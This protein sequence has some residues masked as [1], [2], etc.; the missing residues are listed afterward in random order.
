MTVRISPEMCVAGREL[1]EPRLSP[2]GTRLAYSVSWGGRSAIAVVDLGTTGP[3][4]ERLATSEPQPRTG[5]GLGGG[6]GRW[7]VCR[8]PDGE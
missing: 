2:D 7:L 6:C 8:R 1:A 4:L 3:S 5:R